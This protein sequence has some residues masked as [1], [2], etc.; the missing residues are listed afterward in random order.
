MPFTVLK[1]ILFAVN[2]DFFKKN[3]SENT[4]NKIMLGNRLTYTCSI[5]MLNSKFDIWDAEPLSIS[6]WIEK[7][8]CNK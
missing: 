5:A 4:Q 7:F 1:S 2:A 3:G 8:P 6:F